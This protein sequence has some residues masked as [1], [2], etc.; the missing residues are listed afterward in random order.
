MEHSGRYMRY[1]ILYDS[2]DP[3]MPPQISVDIL[4]CDASAGYDADRQLCADD[5]RMRNL[6]VQDSLPHSAT[7]AYHQARKVL[8]EITYRSY[9]M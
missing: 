4:P 7:S 5:T 9:S 1:N 6:S 8:T 3:F 2:A